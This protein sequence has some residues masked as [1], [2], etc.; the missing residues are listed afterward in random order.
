[1]YTIGVIQINITVQRIAL[2]RIH[3]LS[4]Q[5]HVSPIA[6]C[7]CDSIGQYVCG[8][9]IA[10]LSITGKFKKQLYRCYTHW[11]RRFCRMRQ[12]PCNGSSISEFQSSANLQRTN[13]IL[14]F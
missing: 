14:N 5:I 4:Q 6:N 10:S 12:L 13:C 9:S 8:Q 1:M 7:V 3:P 2:K 11:H